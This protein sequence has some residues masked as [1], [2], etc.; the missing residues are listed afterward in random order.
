MAEPENPILAAALLV[1]HSL[2]YFTFQTRHPD[3]YSSYSNL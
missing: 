2:R 3:R 1:L